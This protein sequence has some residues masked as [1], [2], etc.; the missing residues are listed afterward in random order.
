MRAMEGSLSN[1]KNY[2]L[3][4]P[5][6][7][8]FLVLL[9]S[10]VIAFGG[11]VSYI[12]ATHG[13][14]STTIVFKGNDLIG[15]R[16]LTNQGTETP[17]PSWDGQDLS[18][19]EPD[20]NDILT[21]PVDVTYKDANKDPTHPEQIFVR[22]CVPD[23]TNVTFKTYNNSTLFPLTE[24]G[25]DTSFFQGDIVLTNNSAKVDPNTQPV[26]NG[27]TFRICYDPIDR[28]PNSVKSFFPCEPLPPGGDPVV[29]E[30]FPRAEFTFGMSGGKPGGDVEVSD[31]FILSGYSDF[32]PRYP[33]THPVGLTLTGEAT[34]ITVEISYANAAFQNTGKTETDAEIGYRPYCGLVETPP[35]SGFFVDFKGQPCTG[36]VPLGGTLDTGTKTITNISQPETGCALS[37]DAGGLATNLQDFCGIA[38]EYAIIVNSPGFGGGGGGLVSPSLIV[39]ALGGLAIF[40]APSS[41][42]PAPP[43]PPPGGNGDGGSLGAD[44]TAAALA[45]SP[46]LLLL[47]TGYLSDDLRLLLETHDPYRVLEPISDSE[48]E[49]PITI[50]G[51]GYPIT[52][53]SNTITTNIVY[54]GEPVPLK[55]VYYETDLV[56]V[57]LYTNLRDANDKIYDSDTYIIYNKDKPIEI[58]DPNGYFSDVDLTVN[59]VGAVKYEVNFDITFAKPMEKSDIILRAWDFGLSSADI[60]IEDAWEVVEPSDLVKQEETPET[61]LLA[62]E[63]IET[64]PS[65]IES[66]MGPKK[67]PVWIK[68]NAKW[69]AEGQIRDS[70]FIAGVEYLIE[71]EIID[72]LETEPSEDVADLEEIPEWVKSNAGWWAQGLI[73][74]DDFVWGIEFLIEK[75]IINV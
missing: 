36:F 58:V 10:S 63:V 35:G 7:T 17:V 46:P 50:D 15:I 45:G 44:P 6:K 69:W 5:S 59:K 67:I 21:I 56:H 18:E 61:D 71:Q 1:M 52:G 26:S 66:E 30:A 28:T 39:N 64:E 11:L 9:I 49:M 22:V 51:K 29:A 33:V 32:I 70:D 53:R 4:R 42:P 27:E 34:S 13:I 60:A 37:T 8:L 24:T 54:S 68:N 62:E 41:P 16:D 25:D 2:N 47:W 74:D 38:G 55:L 75:G 19:L 31:A 73:S 12:D 14:I 48:I 57:G 23:C 40:T 3:A 65:V 43:P 72:V 20:E